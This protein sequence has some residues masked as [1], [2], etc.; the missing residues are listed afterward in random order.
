MVFVSPGNFQSWLVW[1]RFSL[2]LFA[3]LQLNFQALMVNDQ[4]HHTDIANF[5]FKYHVHWGCFTQLFQCTAAVKNLKMDQ[6][7]LQYQA[8]LL[9]FPVHAGVKNCKWTGICLL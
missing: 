8:A 4:S 1:V 5:F 2:G 7:L 3:V 9:N 6:N